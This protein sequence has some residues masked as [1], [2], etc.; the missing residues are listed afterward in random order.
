MWEKDYLKDIA[1]AS[2]PLVA[3][4]KFIKTDFRSLLEEFFTA[5]VVAAEFPYSAGNYFFEP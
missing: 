4:M 5:A 3:R 1:A 2:V